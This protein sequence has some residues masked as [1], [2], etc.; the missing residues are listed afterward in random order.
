MDN[1]IVYPDNN[2]YRRNSTLN[3]LQITYATVQMQ[4]VEGDFPN[5]LDIANVPNLDFLQV[6]Q[7]FIV[8]EML[9]LDV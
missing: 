3:V 4:D 5:I 6:Y 9:K 2:K 1:N 8:L 7:L